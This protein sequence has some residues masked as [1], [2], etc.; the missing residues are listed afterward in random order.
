MKT[1]IS[2][3]SELVLSLPKSKYFKDYDSLS[4]GPMLL[5]KIR[6][7]GPVTQSRPAG[8][9]HTQI[10]KLSMATFTL[11]LR[12]SLTSSQTLGQHIMAC[13]LEIYVIVCPVISKIQIFFCYSS[14]INALAGVV[15]AKS[16]IAFPLG[17]LLSISNYSLLGLIHMSFQASD[18]KHESASFQLLLLYLYFLS[19]RNVICQNTTSCSFSAIF[20]LF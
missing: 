8:G 5:Q 4:I 19:I 13:L 16:K 15:L 3:R 7:Q 10:R 2:F 14:Y 11:M 1:K 17:G 12:A 9:A 20:H 18:L 6:F